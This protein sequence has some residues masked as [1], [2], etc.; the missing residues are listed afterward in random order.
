MLDEQSVQIIRAFNR[1]YTVWLDVLNNGYLGTGLNWPEA[2]VIFHIW[3]NPGCS[4][5]ELCRAQRMDKGQVSRILARFKQAGYI[6]RR[7]IPGS[8]G[9]MNIYLTKAG[10]AKAAEIDRNG[11]TQVQEKLG[12]LSSER[13]AEL[14]DAIKVIDNVLDECKGEV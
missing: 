2:R 4:A 14:C 10:E 3:R 9:A 6:V 1:R 8:R 5:A 11:T 7:P 13:I 12:S